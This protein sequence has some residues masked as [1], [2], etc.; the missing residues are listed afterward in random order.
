[1]SNFRLARDFSVL[2]LVL[3]LLVSVA[4]SYAYSWNAKQEL[5]RQGEEKV[6]AVS[7]L[8]YNAIGQAVRAQMLSLFKEKSAPAKNDPRVLAL[9]AEFKQLVGRTSVQKLKLYNF[10][11]MTLY[12]SEAA[13]I[14]KLM[15]DH[16]AVQA[17]REGRRATD[18][19]FRESF[20]S[21]DGP[22]SNVFL[23]GTCMPVTD[24]DG[25][26]LGIIEVYDDVTTVVMQLERT[27]YTVFGVTAGLM[28]VLYAGL[29]FLVV[30]A[31][32][33]IQRD[34]RLLQDEVHK[35][36]NA[37]TLAERE[38]AVAQ[39][40]RATAER[41]RNSADVAR[42]DADRANRAKTQFLANMSHE[43]RTPMNG[44]VGFSDLLLMEKLEPRHRDWVGMISNAAASLIGVV[45]DILDLS[46]IE[47][48]KLALQPERTAM[49]ALVEQ[50]VKSLQPE[51][52]RKGLTITET[53]A[54]D[55]PHM[56]MCDPLRVKQVL[57]NLVGNAIKF[58]STGRVSVDV[59][60]VKV[61]GMAQLAIVVRDT[62][63][64]ISPDDMRRIFHPFEQV[65]SSHTRNYAGTG[66]GLAISQR[67]LN[68]MGGTIR[69]ESQLGIGSAFTM[70]IPLTP[71]NASANTTAPVEMMPAETNLGVRVLLVED[72]RANQLV[73]RAMLERLGCTVVIAETGAEGVRQAGIGNFAAVLMD[74]QMPEMNGLEACVRIR[75]SELATGATPVPII[76]V[77]ANVLETDRAACQDAGM[78]DFLGKPYQLADLARVLQPYLSEDAQQLRRITQLT[79]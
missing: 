46:K 72:N 5:T 47:A 4:L 59:H 37:L 28:L 30:R 51:A 71:V 3:I 26:V 68:M 8:V 17:A 45:N 19:I 2:S 31:D 58:T 9:D 13:Q 78:S 34:A 25:K 11:G 52:D 66:L 6:Y 44:I 21:F 12:S 62:G 56:V 76:A 57:L 64:G 22:R 48:G 77:T 32:R 49:R 10:D 36:E 60:I 23:L 38:R 27:R 43:I 50:V 69:V 70:Q 39:E 53:C 24:R 65:D 55:V 15:S 14:G 16:P 61:L 63:I 35:R 7:V 33:Q 20:E 75:A 1:M 79:A 42:A 40:A 73:A 67:L 54:P 29:M 41:E 18:L 74:L